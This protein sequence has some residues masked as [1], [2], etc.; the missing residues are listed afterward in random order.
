MG[1]VTC[2]GLA[3]S[4][5]HKLHGR[6]P[7]ELHKQYN[8]RR[9]SQLGFDEQRPA[10]IESQ[11]ESHG[12]TGYGGAGHHF[13]NSPAVAPH[14]GDTVIIVGAGA[15]GVHMASELQNRGIKCIILEKEN[16]VGGKCFTIVH[17]DIPHEMGAVYLNPE[18][19]LPKELLRKYGLGNAFTPILGHADKDGVEVTTVHTDNHTAKHY[20]NLHAWM[21]AGIEE[22]WAGRDYSLVPNNL[23]KAPFLRAMRRYQ[24]A[25]HEVM[26]KYYGTLPVRPTQ[27]TWNKELNMTYLDWL[28]HH[29][30][31]AIIPLLE[32]VVSSQGYGYLDTLPAYYGLVWFTADLAEAFI[33]SR[34]DPENATPFFE[35][36]KGGWS[37]LFE[38][39]VKDDQLDV[40]LQH[41]VKRID[42]LENEVIVSGISKVHNKENGE[43]ESV[44]FS[45]KGSH[46]FIACPFAQVKETL[47]LNDDEKDI[48]NSLIPFCFTTTLVEMDPNPNRT[49]SLSFKPDALSPSNRNRAPGEVFLERWSAKAVYPDEPSPYEC[50]PT[51]NP[52][53]SQS[54]DNLHGHSYYHD[55]QVR[56]TYQFLDAGVRRT[57]GLEWA[58]GPLDDDAGKDLREQV[59]NATASDGATDVKILEQYKWEHFYHYNQENLRKGLLWKLLANQGDNRTFFIGASAVFDSIN[60]VLNYNRVIMDHFFPLSHCPVAAISMEMERVPEEQPPDHDQVQESSCFC[61]TPGAK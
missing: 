39:M 12:F 14:A 49:K 29:G 55:K 16:R 54:A 42:R 46:V 21:M 34:R 15:A 30:C 56:V 25:H 1:C 57:G 5:L 38:N 6:R 27:D 36:L 58:A 10:S 41:E 33:E 28:N 4:C 9:S 40:K 3:N 60:D 11:D 20:D 19:N 61:T 2:C 53:L 7:D 50:P 44:K 8:H 35:I 22:E 37:R 52:F 23:N 31:G 47:E 48:I 32:I 26:G 51:G 13:K 43:M 18:Y 24:E 59:E 45:I 17:G